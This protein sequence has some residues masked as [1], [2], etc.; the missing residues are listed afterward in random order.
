M[1]V[2]TRRRRSCERSRVRALSQPSA[3]P[4]VLCPYLFTR[5]AYVAATGLIDETP[6]GDAAGTPPGTTAPPAWKHVYPDG[7]T[8]THQ[9]VEVLPNGGGDSLLKLDALAPFAAQRDQLHNALPNASRIAL[10]TE[11]GAEVAWTWAA[12]QP[13]A[14]DTAVIQRLS[15]SGGALPR[16]GSGPLCAREPRTLTRRG[17]NT[18]LCRNGAS[19]AG[20][21]AGTR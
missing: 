3:P 21:A 11:A 17:V 6:S 20:T 10:W 9:W 19:S 16:D 4:T 12:V 14:E 15:N 7:S 18:A 5:C 8:S 13:T 1:T 2:V